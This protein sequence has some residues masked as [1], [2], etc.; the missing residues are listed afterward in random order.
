MESVLATCR[1][2]VLQYCD[3][4]A[5]VRLFH[6]YGDLFGDGENVGPYIVGEIV[7]IF[8]VIVWHDN[9][10][11]WVIFDPKRVDEGSYFDVFVNYVLRE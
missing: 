9:H 1:L 2:V 3:A 4:V 6:G 11:T 7:D 8:V 10:V 5:L